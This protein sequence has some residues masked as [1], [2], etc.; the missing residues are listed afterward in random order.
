MARYAGKSVTGDVEFYIAKENEHR[1]RHYL[2]HWQ[3]QLGGSSVWRNV[4]AVACHAN[5]IGFASI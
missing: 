4:Y 1:M 5:A 2:L 3:F